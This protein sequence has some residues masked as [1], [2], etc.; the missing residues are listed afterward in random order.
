M[1]RI[2]FA[3]KQNVGF[4]TPELIER[5][6]NKA[7]I[8][9]LRDAGAFVRTKASQSMKRPS[10]KRKGEASAPGS[11]PNAHNAKGTSG[12]K[13]IRFQYDP[14]SDSV[15][16]GPLKFNSS[17]VGFEASTTVPALHEYGETAIITERRWIPL[18][19]WQRPGPWRRVNSKTKKK[20]GTRYESRTRTA[21]YPAR[22]FMAPALAAEAPKFPDLFGNSI[23]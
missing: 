2:T 16:V 3:I 11:P 15:L 19:S 7:R 13:T 17:V 23:K 18:K 5:A 14:Q 6:L 8:L 22:P 1:M 10:K 12:L 9:R 20:P 4:F 21:K